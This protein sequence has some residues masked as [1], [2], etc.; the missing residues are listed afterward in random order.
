MTKIVLFVNGD[1]LSAVWTA[2]Y[3]TT[4]PSSDLEHSTSQSEHQVQ[5]TATFK[6]KVFGRLFVVH[7][8]TA[9]DETLLCW[10]DALL[11]F[12]AFLDALD[13]VC[14]FDIQLDLF[15]GE[16]LDFDQHFGLQLYCCAM[17]GLT[18]SKYA[19]KT[20]SLS[21]NAYGVDADKVGGR[22]IVNTECGGGQEDRSS[23]VQGSAA[24]TRDQRCTM[25]HVEP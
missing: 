8:F 19:S 11:L 2:S 17:L 15:A 21:N 13:L 23:N 16:C 22:A 1:M 7:L 4:A 14:L 25:H 5:N 20:A 9:K 6:A 18:I 12:N 10:W 24:H 3:N